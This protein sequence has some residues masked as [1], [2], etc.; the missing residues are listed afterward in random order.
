[1]F[2]LLLSLG[3]LLILFL[4]TLVIFCVH[5][6]L[7]HDIDVSTGKPPAGS[8]SEAD[9][10]HVIAYKFERGRYRDAGHLFTELCSLLTRPSI[11]LGLYFDNPNKVCFSLL[12][13][14]FCQV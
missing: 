14:L 8:L 6:G 13:D 3:L 1:M 11:T 9:Q 12:F 10:P 5:S 2:W 7:L 4:A